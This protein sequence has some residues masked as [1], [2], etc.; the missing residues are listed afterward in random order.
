MVICITFHYLLGN[1]PCVKRWKKSLT[2]WPRTSLNQLASL[3]HVLQWSLPHHA[4]AQRGSH[5][6]LVNVHSLYINLITARAT[7]TLQKKGVPWWPSGFRIRCC[8]HYGAGSISGPGTSS[9]YKLCQ[10]GIVSRE[11][12]LKVPD[13]RAKNWGA[14]NNTNTTS[15]R[16]KG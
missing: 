11:R 3:I 10:K 9:C 16:H 5:R 7:L 13:T 2:S 12:E 14:Q 6:V 15:R 1:K 4:W 8:H